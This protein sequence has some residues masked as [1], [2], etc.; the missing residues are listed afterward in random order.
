MRLE[1]RDREVRVSKCEMD[2]TPGGNFFVT[3]FE[4]HMV[5]NVDNLNMTPD[6]QQE[7]GPYFHNY[8]ENNTANKQ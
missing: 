4:D 3:S 1:V 2:S 8:K 6:R 5:R 7:W